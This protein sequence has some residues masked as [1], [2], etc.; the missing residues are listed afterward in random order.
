MCWVPLRSRTSPSITSGP[1]VPKLDSV[2]VF[3]LK[4]LSIW[5]RLP[6]IMAWKDSVKLFGF[7]PRPFT[8]N[9]IASSDSK[10][11]KKSVQKAEHKGQ[12]WRKLMR[13]SAL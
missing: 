7:P 5:Q 11:I 12:K 6:S 8:A 1:G 2:L 3:V 4:S 13:S 10:L 9:Y